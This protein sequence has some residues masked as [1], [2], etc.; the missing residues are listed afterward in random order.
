VLGFLQAG[1][2]FGKV[3]NEFSAGSKDA[4]GTGLGSNSNGFN[5]SYVIAG[6][7]KFDPW[8]IKVDFRQDGYDT[9]V[10]TLSSAC[11]SGACTQFTTIDGGYVTI[12]AFRAKQSTLDARLEYQIGAYPDTYIGVGFLQAAN[13]YGYPVLKGIGAGVE[14]MARY[15]TSWDWFGSAFYYP[16]SNGTYIQQSVSSPTF[17]Q[18]FKQSYNIIKYDVGLNVNFV[19]SPF[20]LYGGFSGDR[21]TTKDS[22]EPINQTHSGP[23]VGLGVHF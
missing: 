21:Y 5:G 18:S 16:N 19:G 8:A 12:D 7:Y 23:Y 20:Y 2:T 1:A 17:G 4:Q 22:F 13:N 9:T 3:Y 11:P 10:S 15:D 6:A 14:K